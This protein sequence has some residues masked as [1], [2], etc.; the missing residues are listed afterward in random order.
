MVLNK[1][2]ML[3]INAEL[4]ICN[5]VYT[6]EPGRKDRLIAKKDI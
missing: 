4:Y 5:A 1:K 6:I 3:S 2:W